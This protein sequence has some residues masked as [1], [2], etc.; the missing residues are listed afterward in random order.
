MKFDKTNA[1]IVASTVAVLGI[2]V[3]TYRTMDPVIDANIDYAHTNEIENSIDT[4]FYVCDDCDAGVIVNGVGECCL[5]EI[6]I[7]GEEQ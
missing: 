6:L 3:A 5:D 2:S 7:N 4:G 1:G